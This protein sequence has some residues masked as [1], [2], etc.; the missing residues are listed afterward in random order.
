MFKRRPVSVCIRRGN[1]YMSDLVSNLQMRVVRLLK[2]PMQTA[3]GLSGPYSSDD[4]ISA[5]NL[6][7]GRTTGIVRWSVEVDNKPVAFRI[8][9]A[10][11]EG[12]LFVVKHL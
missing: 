9:S 11:D 10:V 5:L 2:S 1:R 8:T 12:E 3:A 4:I 7:P 6:N